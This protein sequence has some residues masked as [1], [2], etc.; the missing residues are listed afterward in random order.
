MESGAIQGIKLKNVFTSLLVE[1]GRLMHLTI[2][3]VEAGPSRSRA[4]R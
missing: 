3:L 2:N 1:V 4:K